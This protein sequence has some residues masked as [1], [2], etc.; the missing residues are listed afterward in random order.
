V[1]SNW[2]GV[3]GPLVERPAGQ[4]DLSKSLT[5]GQGRLKGR[6]IVEEFEVADP[7]DDGIHIKISFFDNVTDPAEVRNYGRELSKKLNARLDR[8]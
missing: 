7:Q 1:S 6:I 2:E 8:G 3:M 4:P 5:G